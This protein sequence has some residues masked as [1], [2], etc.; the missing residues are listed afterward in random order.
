MQHYTDDVWSLFFSLLAVF[1]NS[2]FCN[3]M[4]SVVENSDWAE[5]PSIMHLYEAKL[6]KV[7][8]IDCHFVEVD[9]A[10][11]Q[12][13]LKLLSEMFLFHKLNNFFNHLMYPLLL[14]LCV[15]LCIIC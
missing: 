14:S 8:L 3:L 13:C 6:A 5:M 1:R 12:C 4:D 2:R 10:S 15:C 7:R 9:A 11:H